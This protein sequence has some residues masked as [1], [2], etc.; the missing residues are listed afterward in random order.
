MF[1]QLISGRGQCANCDGSGNFHYMPLA[2]FDV[3]AGKRYRFRVASNAYLNCPFTVSVQ[4]HKM[5]MIASDGAP[6]EGVPVSNFVIHAGERYDFVLHANAT[7]G[8]YYLMVRG[9]L[10]C[11]AAFTKARQ[12][13]IIHYKGQPAFNYAQAIPQWENMIVN[14]VVR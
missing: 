4:G 6:F 14:G 8:N 13:G 9:M 2:T 11:G 1:S 10:D 5:L 12:A 3:D 7:P